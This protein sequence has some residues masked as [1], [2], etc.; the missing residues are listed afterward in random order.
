MPL[1]RARKDFLSSLDNEI[2][3]LEGRIRNF[4]GYRLRFSEARGPIDFN[5]TSIGFRGPTSTLR[6]SIRSPE[7]ARRD[8][9]IK[10]KELKEN[11]ANKGS[12]SQPTRSL[13]SASS[14]SGVE[15]V[16]PI[17]SFIEDTQF[18]RIDPLQEEESAV[19]SVEQEF[20][21]SRQRELRG[22]GRLGISPTS[23]RA[24]S[25]SQRRALT[26]AI[27]RSG[28]R[29]EARKSTGELN[30]Q[31]QMAG[32]ELASSTR[33]QDITQRGQDISSRDASISR[34][35][36]G[37][38]RAQTDVRSSQLRSQNRILSSVNA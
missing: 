26:L 29:L 24:R 23:G 5:E 8:D 27:A 12:S 13:R 38:Q 4:Q 33:A 7:D 19:R 34:L 9:Q 37:F 10:L 17:S 15:R 11:R 3:D 22:F 32:R 6:K 14:Q 1:G 36:E 18:N 2:S 20:S 21:G 28:A 25:S 16:A 35:S 30:F 31:R